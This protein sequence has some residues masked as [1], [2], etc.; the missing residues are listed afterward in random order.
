MYKLLSHSVKTFI[1]AYIYSHRNDTINVN[2][3]LV[4]AWKKDSGRCFNDL[5]ISLMIPYNHTKP[6]SV[7]VHI[8]DHDDVAAKCK[9]HVTR[10]TQKMVDQEEYGLAMIYQIQLYR[11]GL[12]K[13]L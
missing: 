6:P 9:D 1:N 11:W 2:N 8:F 10:K 12:Q 4:K 5:Y 13:C 7:D 3:D